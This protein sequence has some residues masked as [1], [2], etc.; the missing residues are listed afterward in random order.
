MRLSFLEYSID[1]R[2]LSALHRSGIGGE[3]SS[4]RAAHP[5]FPPPTLEAVE[6][7][8]RL[9]PHKL[10]AVESNWVTLI[11]KYKLEPH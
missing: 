4:Q 5:P 2:F 1:S 11:N 9:N 7:R 6:R 3:S 8:G 10:I